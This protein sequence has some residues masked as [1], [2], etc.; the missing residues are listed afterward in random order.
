MFSPTGNF[1][2]AAATTGA[3]GRSS[4]PQE[5]EDEP[6][7]TPE[8]FRSAAL[9]DFAER[10]FTQVC[11]QQLR[12]REEEVRAL[13]GTYGFRIRGGAQADWVIDYA[14]AAV[15]REPSEGA[16][17]RIELDADDFERLVGGRLDVEEAMAAGRFRLAGQT[18]LL[19]R[20]GLA[21]PPT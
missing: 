17:L 19:S 4:H 9:Q 1:R 5:I 12:D 20:V 14:D 15:R 16:Q 10:F 3:A 13:G 8:G 7:D 2:L 11:P 6:D 21:F 18:S